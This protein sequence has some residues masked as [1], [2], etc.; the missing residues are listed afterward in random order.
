MKLYLEIYQLNFMFFSYCKYLQLV[1]NT[2]IVNVCTT[3]NICKIVLNEGKV[4]I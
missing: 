2:Q 3:L 4:R 1:L